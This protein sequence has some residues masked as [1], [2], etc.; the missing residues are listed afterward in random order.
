[1]YW[2]KK[3]FKCNYAGNSWQF[4]VKVFTMDQQTNV[5]SITYICVTNLKANLV[6]WAYWW[7]QYHIQ[8]E[9]HNDLGLRCDSDS[10]A[11]IKK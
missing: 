3:G 4:I 11:S 1:M 8:S 6:I 9:M 2:R 7:L 10:V 5:K